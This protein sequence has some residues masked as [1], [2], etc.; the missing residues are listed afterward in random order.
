VQQAQRKASKFNTQANPTQRREREEM[1]Y[2]TMRLLE[3]ASSCT[4]TN[5]QSKGCW[6]VKK[7]H[8]HARNCP[9]KIGGGCALCKH[10]WCLLNLHAKACVKPECSVPRCQYA[11]ARC[12]LASDAIAVKR[13]LCAC[14]W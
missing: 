5:C 10:M 1:I 8:Q 14:S 4:N 6:K 11:L 12:M 2:R 3:H 13:D 9:T 7:L